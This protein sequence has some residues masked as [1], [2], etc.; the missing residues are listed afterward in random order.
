MADNKSLHSICRWTF[1]PGKGG[2]V[3]GNMRPEWGKDFTTVDMINLVKKDIA[4]RL[5][6]NVELG[7][8]VHYDNEVCE[9]TAPEIAD[10]LVANGMYLAMITPGAHGHFGYGGISS[11]DPKERSDADKFG[12]RTVDLG[13][14]ILKKAWHNDI[15]LCQ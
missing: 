13:Y 12:A 5:P 2:F 4:P 8:E 3:P 11:L 14:S 15:R 9:K 10:A 1:N 7:L 6:E